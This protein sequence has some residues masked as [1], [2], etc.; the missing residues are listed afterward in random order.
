LSIRAV[1][2]VDQLAPDTHSCLLVTQQYDFFAEVDAA[3]DPNAACEGSQFLP[4]HHPEPPCTRFSP[5]VSYQFLPDTA[6]LAPTFRIELAERLHFQNWA[7]RQNVLTIFR[8]CDFED[9]PSCIVELAPIATPV[10]GNP[11]NHAFYLPEVIKN[12]TQGAAD[13][14]HQTF[15]ETVQPPGGDPRPYAGCPECIHLHWR[16]SNLLLHPNFNAGRPL[17]DAGST[18]SVDL[19]VVNKGTSAEVEDP[20]GAF[21]AEPLTTPVVWLLGRNTQLF[22]TFFLYDGFVFPAA[23][24]SVGAT[25][26]PDPVRTG[27]TVTYSVQVGNSGP[28]PSAP[29][30]AL[31]VDLRGSVFAAVSAT[32]SKGSCGADAAP[33]PQRV[34][35]TCQLGTLAQGE[36]VSVTIATRALQAGRI[37]GNFTVQGLR[38][39]QSIQNNTVQRQIRVR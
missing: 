4:L 22:D 3:H 33:E 30:V 17:I 31:E 24:L 18:Q 7:R 11:L 37:A 13:N 35:L 2:S 1:Y 6:A 12:G 21:T 15:N 29:D 39:D 27:E 9:I 16:W 26:S 28:A 25:G 20:T 14:I 34:Q 10:E 5:S 23:N 38:P 36:Q 8:D 32:P 19:A